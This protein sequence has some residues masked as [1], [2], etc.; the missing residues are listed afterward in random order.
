LFGRIISGRIVDANQV[1]VN[2]LASLSTDELLDR[3]QARLQPRGL[4]TSFGGRLALLG[5]TVHHQDIRRPLDLP[6]QIPGKRLRCVLGDSL[7][8]PELPGWHPARGVRLTTT[9]LDWSHGKGSELTGPA[10]AVLMAVTG[11]HS[12]TGELTGPGQQV[13]ASRLARRQ[14]RMDGARPR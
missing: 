1:W 8:T 7:R 14:R 13:V 11:R 10:E 12:V 3:A 5:A 9:D 6:R 2:E 4:A